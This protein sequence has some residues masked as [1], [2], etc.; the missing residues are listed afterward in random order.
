MTQASGTISTHSQKSVSRRAALTGA[1]AI[2]VAVPTSAIA[3]PRSA[4][5]FPD[6]A[7]ELAAVRDRYV[8]HHLKCAAHTEAGRAY[9]TATTG[10]TEDEA[11][12]DQRNGLN[13]RTEDGPKW[14][15]WWAAWGEYEA[16]HP[17]Y[18]PVDEHGSSIAWN[19]IHAVLYP[20]CRAI[21]KQPTLSTADYA[22]QVQAFALLNACN[23]LEDSVVNEWESG[24][25]LAE[26]ACSIWGIDLIPGLDLRP[27]EI[28]EEG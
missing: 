22:V 5:S 27:V 13:E 12:A 25:R 20:T 10:I 14:I 19:E 24:G 9:A 15:A 1:A 3:G 11:R 18:D 8:A 2:T 28:D 6:L 4:C 21:L 17:N 23:F 16:A 26:A 7:G